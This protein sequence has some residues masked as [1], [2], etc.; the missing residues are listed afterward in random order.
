MI[1]PPEPEPII[2][3]TLPKPPRQKWKPNL[4]TRVI[5]RLVSFLLCVVLVHT[6]LLTALLVDIQLLSDKDHVGRII[7]S[8]LR[9]EP[10]INSLSL[11][12][13]YGSRKGSSTVHDLLVS[14]VYDALN[15]NGDGDVTI[16][17]DQISEFLERSSADEFIREKATGF[18]S[19]FINGTENTHISS[20]D[21]IALMEENEA[22]IEEVFGTKVDG[23]MKADIENFIGENN[24]GGLF[25]QQITD[26]IKN[27]RIFGFSINDLLQGLRA[28]TSPV[29]MVVLIILDFVLIGLLFLTNWLRLWATMR[30]TGVCLSCAGGLLSVPM[31]LLQLMPDILG[32]TV[33]NVINTLLSVIAPVHYIMFGA[34]IVLIIAAFIVKV[35]SKPAT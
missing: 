23:K 1:D 35:T 13:D 21:V 14:V 2:E 9:G 5:L 11:A 16:T 29:T 24:I 18:V 6:L 8:A 19:D 27:I 28:L 10:A 32:G 12:R 17:K 33:A 4:L 31:V 25:H 34:G 20:D 26:T 7:E 22:L 3:E 30:C 15:D